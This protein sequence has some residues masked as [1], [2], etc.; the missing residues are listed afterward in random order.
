MTKLAAEG[1]ANK[2]LNKATGLAF[3]TAA[4]GAGIAGLSLTQMNLGSFFNSEYS[5]A[6]Q[7]AKET[8]LLWGLGIGLG[9]LLMRKPIGAG[10]RHLMGAQTTGQAF[11]NLGKG[12]FDNVV[13]TAKEIERFG[14]RPLLTGKGPHT[15]K[16]KMLEAYFP[17][18]N[19]HKG[20]NPER[21][22]L[23]PTI[24][25]RMIAAG[26]GFGA[27]SM[28]METALPTA[29]PPSVYYDGTGMRHANDMGMN[30]TQANSILGPNSSLSGHN[31]MRNQ[32]LS[33]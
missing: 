17:F 28:G 10:F 1:F 21:L 31:A 20:L 8:P 6:R 4:M 22:G 26:A 24:T 27:I 7:Q 23:N 3:G 25:R 30:Y 32:I 29:A 9:A 14:I 19:A 16:S 33:S 11:T 2:A 5:P 15:N 12:I 13:G 18:F